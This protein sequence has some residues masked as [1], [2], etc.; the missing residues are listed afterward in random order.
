MIIIEI[1][2]TSSIFII[3]QGKVSKG[4]VRNLRQSP[5]AEPSV[6]VDSNYNDKISESGRAA[7]INNTSSSGTGGNNFNGIIKKTSTIANNSS[8]SNNNSSN[9]GGS[10][11]YNNSNI[12]I[13]NIPYMPVPVIHPPKKSHKKGGGKETATSSSYALSAQGSALNG[14]VLAA[15]RKADMQTISS[16]VPQPTIISQRQR[17]QEMIGKASV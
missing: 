8:N 11:S 3:L 7:Q 9:N 2:Y 6:P 10:D 13:T 14:Q 1:S 5:A 15:E 4:T 12:S 16:F 17:R